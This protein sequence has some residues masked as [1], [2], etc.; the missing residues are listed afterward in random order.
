MSGGSGRFYRAPLPDGKRMK[1]R[2]S[3][4]ERNVEKQKIRSEIFVLKEQKSSVKCLCA[5]FRVLAAALTDK[6]EK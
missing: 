5:F 1:Q 4:R 2:G 6:N 3:G